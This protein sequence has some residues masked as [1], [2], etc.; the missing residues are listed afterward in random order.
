MAR[1]EYTPVNDAYRLNISKLRTELDKVFDW[2]LR[3]PG[4]KADIAQT[5]VTFA[6]AA[7]LDLGAA[8]PAT[9]TIVANGATSA[10]EPT[11]TFTTTTTFTV[12]GGAITAITLS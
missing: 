7:G 11:G 9:Q 10:V 2:T 5:L 12:A 3:S 1:P 4:A 6:L 8:L